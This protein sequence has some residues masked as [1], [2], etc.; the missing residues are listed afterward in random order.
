MVKYLKANIFSSNSAYRALV[1]LAVGTV[2]GG[3]VV[4]GYGSSRSSG[5]TTDNHIA[6]N[7]TAIELVEGCI[8]ANTGSGACLQVISGVTNDH[9]IF[10]KSGG[11]LVG[12]FAA[13]KFQ[14]SASGATTITPTNPAGTGLEV[15]ATMSGAKVVV[16]KQGAGSGM[17]VVNGSDGGG[18]C[19]QDSDGAGWTQCSYL[20]GTQTCATVAACSQ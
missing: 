8:A 10:T 9:Y 4:F 20:N 11:L 12:P 5:H 13:P 1:Y 14:I 6:A 15:N 17:I 19:F 18:S 2:I 16:N 3:G 7:L